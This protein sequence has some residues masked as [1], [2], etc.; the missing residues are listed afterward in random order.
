MQVFRKESLYAYHS[1]SK[2]DYA[3]EGWKRTPMLDEYLNW[4]AER[5]EPCER[6]FQVIRG[7]DSQWFTILIVKET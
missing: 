5:L 3:P 1:I 4:L 2:S 7:G 6:I